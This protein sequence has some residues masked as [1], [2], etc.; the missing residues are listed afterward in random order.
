MDK[1]ACLRK[2]YPSRS[3]AGI[4]ADSQ[5]AVESGFIKP[6]TVWL[7]NFRRFDRTDAARN[8][9][10]AFISA[11]LGCDAFCGRGYA[12]APQNKSITTGIA[13]WFIK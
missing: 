10:D 9:D 11:R 5:S 12:F 6:K 8:I 13:F 3:V 2:Y 7:H 4:I 1:C